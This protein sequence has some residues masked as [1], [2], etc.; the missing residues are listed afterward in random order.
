[1]QVCTFSALFPAATK[2]GIYCLCLCG[3]LRQDDVLLTDDLA[4][5][6][7]YH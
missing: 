2:G 5:V 1:M 3:E 6:M 4:Y 7:G